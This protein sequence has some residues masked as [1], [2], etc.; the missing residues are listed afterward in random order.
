MK[1]LSFHVSTTHLSGVTYK[2]GLIE[3]QFN[4]LLSEY[5]P[6]FFQKLGIDLKEHLIVYTICDQLC[7]CKEATLN[8]VPQNSIKKLIPFYESSLFPLDDKETHLVTSYERKKGS[9]H[10]TS[11]AIL[12]EFLLSLLSDLELLTLCPD[13]LYSWQKALE[14]SFTSFINSQ[15]EQLI[16]YQ[17]EEILY[18]LHKNGGIIST[19]TLVKLTKS[20]FSLVPILNALK[21]KIT[22]SDYE[23]YFIGDQAQIKDEIQKEFKELIT[24]KLSIKPSHLIHLGACMLADKN[25]HNLLKKLPLKRPISTTSLF[26]RINKI[27]LITSL[28]AILLGLFMVTKQVY[29]EHKIK[30]E[31]SFQNSLS[32]D[33]TL[34]EV[35]KLKL[36]KTI[37]I[38]APS[39]LEIMAFFSLH[40]V[41]CKIDDTSS[42]ST[43]FTNLKYELISSQKAKVTIS[44]NFP[45]D[46]IRLDFEKNLKLKKIP[47]T[48]TSMAHTTTYEMEFSKYHIL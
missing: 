47:F 32:L 26:Q 44:L 3:S 6:L 23:V 16:F 46:V 13:G 7:L 29:Q 1:I 17:Q 27:N 40:P 8:K 34:E 42:L 45:S 9:Y 24:P 12:K 18:V 2:N 19:S 48:S 36:Y 33:Q 11:H 35:D 31:L 38:E 25:Q 39:P 22:Q 28:F 41:L 5:S 15:K 37:A 21:N 30:L 43:S 20:N 14:I 4:I 10:L